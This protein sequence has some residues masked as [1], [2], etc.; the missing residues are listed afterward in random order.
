MR[1]R[2]ERNPLPNHKGKGVVVVVIHRNL[3][4]VEAEE[5]EGSF[6]PNTIRTL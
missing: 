3:T 2:G 1:T 4:D 5:S 6:H